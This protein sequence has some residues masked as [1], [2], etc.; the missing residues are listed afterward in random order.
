MSKEGRDHRE[1]FVIDLNGVPPQSP[2][3]KSSG[4]IKE[5]A[6]KYVGVSYNK[7]DN[8]WQAHIY[9][10]GKQRIIGYYDDEEEAAGD[11]ARALF[12]YRVNR[13]YYVGRTGNQDLHT[14]KC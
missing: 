1:S 13:E 4:R 12:K 6:S 8:M 7:R 11:Y 9:F 14:T 3:P 2:V 10:D 5:G